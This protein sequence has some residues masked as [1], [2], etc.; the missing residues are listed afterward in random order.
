MTKAKLLPY[1]NRFTGEV[2][3]LPRKE[4]KLLNEDWARAKMVTN[5]DGDRVFR[6]KLDAS[7]RG[8]DGKLHNGTAIVDLTPTDEPVELE[9]LNGN[10]DTE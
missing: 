1:V 6:F 5:Q 3:T 2:K 4:G 8:R 7:V 9:G 10:R